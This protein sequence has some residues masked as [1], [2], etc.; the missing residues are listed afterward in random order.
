MGLVMD[1]MDLEVSTYLDLDY[2]MVAFQKKARYSI[3]VKFL[4]LFPHS[5]YTK[6]LLFHP[7]VNVKTA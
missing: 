4:T 3:E 5:Q 1:N 6:K 2:I 7:N